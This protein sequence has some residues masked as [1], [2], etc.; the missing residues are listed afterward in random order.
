M[1]DGAPTYTNLDATGL[2]V[3]VITARW[4][5][6]LTH[7]LR[8]GAIGRLM[9]LGVAEQ[10][11]VSIDIGGSYE[12]PFA[13]RHLI[14]TTEVDVVIPIGVLVKGSTMH[15][16]YIAEAVSQGI[17]RVSLDT[18]VP[19]LFGVLTCLTEEQAKERA[20]GPGNHGPSWAD[21]AVELGL[22]RKNA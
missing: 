3:G 13:A 12:L 10:D 7:S 18:G 1:K 8:D 5:Y 11:I 14:D 20:I 16:E 21:T 9:E 6:Q 4:N 2:K 17:M 15:F 19:V 22:M